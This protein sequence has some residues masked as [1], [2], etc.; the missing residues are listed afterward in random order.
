MIDWSTGKPAAHANLSI[1]AI[2]FSRREVRTDA[3]GRFQ[4]NLP[5]EDIFFLSASPPRY[6]LLVQTRFGNTVVAMRKGEKFRNLIIPA[7]PATQLSGHVLDSDG[8]PLLGCSVSAVSREDVNPRKSV[9]LNWLGFPVHSRL[10]WE[11]DD[12]NKFYLAEETQTAADGSFNFKRIGA[13][14]FFLLTRCQIRDAI[15]QK[16]D[17]WWQPVFYPAATSLKEAHEILLLPGQHRTGF[18]FHLA[19][20]RTYRL[21]ANPVGSDGS[22]V[23]PFSGEVKVFRADRSLTSTQLGYEDC[24]LNYQTG[25]ILCPALLPGK[26]TLYIQALEQRWTD[27]LASAKVDFT[28]VPKDNQ[29]LTIQLHRVPENVRRRSLTE[30]PH[31]ELNL[32]P[33][34]EISADQTPAILVLAWGAGHSARLCTV[35]LIEKTMLMPLPPDT[36]TLNAIEY[37]FELRG[38]LRSR[39]GEGK[40]FESLLMSHGTAVRIQPGQTSTPPDLP[41]LRTSQLI[42][43]ALAYL[44]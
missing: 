40:K 2:N 15:T 29:R 18:D 39:T 13:D 12:P 37:S 3:Q 34:C 44:R 43:I 6:G 24:A 41:L 26:Y 9:E 28:V 7:I 27:T 38:N 35:S 22:T 30:G 17:S 33:P 5:R 14:R 1:D 36:Y 25:R 10:P 11:D 21:E 42:D 31:G 19:R 23:D 4:F 20:P 8:H 32:N 16:L